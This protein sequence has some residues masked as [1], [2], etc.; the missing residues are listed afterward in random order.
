MSYQIEPVRALSTP[1]FRRL[2]G[3]KPGTFEAMLA[4]LVSREAARKKRGRPPALSLEQQQMT[5]GK[6]LAFRQVVL[7][8]TSTDLLLGILEKSGN[9]SAIHYLRRL[10]NYA[11]GL[12]WLP[13]Q[14]VPPRAW[15]PQHAKRRRAI[16]GAERQRIIAAE[17]N[18]ERRLYYELL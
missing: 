15:P 9:S 12:G 14:V 2:L 16:T 18:Q 10:H 8:E 7:T 4:A 11:L 3:V 6:G 1:D 13:W 5:F 17:S